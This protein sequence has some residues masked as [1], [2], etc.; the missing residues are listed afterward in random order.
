MD[1]ENIVL[2]LLE[3][4]EFI[5]SFLDSRAKTLSDIDGTIAIDTSVAPIR[6]ASKAVSR[7]LDS[8]EGLETLGSGLLELLEMTLD[9]GNVLGGFL[10]LLVK[11]GT[12]KAKLDFVFSGNALF[13]I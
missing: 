1:N 4:N 9:G 3:I 5:A 8:Q 10:E 11:T 12:E 13:E 2:F 6:V 7:G